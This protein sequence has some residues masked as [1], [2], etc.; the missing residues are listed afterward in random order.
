MKV[1]N[2]LKYKGNEVFAVAQTDSVAE[3]VSVLNQHNIG[4]VIVKDE[5]GEVAGIM[6]E[7]DVVRR[8]G[9]KGTAVMSMPVR[10]CMTPA[11]HTCTPEST[12]DE[13]MEEMT[14]KRIRHL[15]VMND[16]S[17]IGVVSIG[18]VVKRKI[19]LAEQE[20]KALKDYIA[21]S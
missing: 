2:I 14:Q 8:L 6:S 7:R 4:A 1:A 3:A 16:G 15:P 21:H 5:K 11:P 13:L 12:V 17:I 18:D 20:A 19:Y 9:V 10:E